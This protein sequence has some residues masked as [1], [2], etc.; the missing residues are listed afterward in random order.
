M[1]RKKKYQIYDFSPYIRDDSLKSYDELVQQIN[2]GYSP[3]YIEYCDIQNIYDYYA[4]MTNLKPADYN[5][6]EDFVLSV[7][8]GFN[9]TCEL[10]F[11]FYLK[12][13]IEN[14]YKLVD[15]RYYFQSEQELA[16]L[17]YVKS[18]DNTVRRN[19]IYNKFLKMPLEKMVESQ[20]N[21]YKIYPTDN[22]TI[23]GL[24]HDT[25]TFILEKITHFDS[26]LN[27]KAYSYLGTISVRHL[28]TLAK[29]AQKSKK[30]VVTYIDFSIS[31]EN[32]EEP[33]QD[34]V[35]PLLEIP[36]IEYI[37]EENLNVEFFNQI[38]IIIKNYIADPVKI[39]LLS[40]EEV[41]LGQA[42]IQLIEHIDDI[43]LGDM[44]LTRKIER[45]DIQAILM[46][47]T[48]LS[49]K[50]LQSCLKTFKDIYITEKYK[51]INNK[52]Y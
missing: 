49:K 11:Y 41:M 4:E 50:K 32:N 25:V 43:F 3:T 29:R 14:K 6:F 13:H 12:S 34:Q 42:I 19:A 15:K 22:G 48:N 17:E 52:N 30:T 21:K 39:K 24:I 45:N 27:T 40:E 9:I 28:M 35:T 7:L 16:V 1:S 20:I 38:P 5:T 26:S 47:M 36:Q 37:E 44:P 31:D 23:L 33:D 46:T 8:D 2:L 10:N 51:L 18:K